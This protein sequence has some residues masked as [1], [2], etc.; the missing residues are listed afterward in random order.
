MRILYV[1][2]TA[3]DY[4]TATL[5]EGLLELGCE[6][7]ASEGSNY[8]D[9]LEDELIPAYA[10]QADLIVVGTN[11][12]VRV[13]LVR[14]MRNPRR[15]FVDGTDF[16][17][18][19]PPA[20]LRFKMIFKRELGRA[21]VDAA[22][23]YVFPL[24]FAA[25]RRYFTASPMQ[26]DILVSFLADLGS[27][28]LRFSIYQRLMN[29]R[30]PLV[31]TGVTGER[32]YRNPPLPQPI[33]TPMYREALNRSLISVSVPG[34]GYDCARYWE[35][36]AAKAM[37]LTFEPDIVIPE[38]FSDG[39]DCVSFRSFE[40]FEAKVAHYGNNV[41]LASAIAERGHARLLSHHTT[42]ARAAYFLEVV[43]RHIDRPGVCEP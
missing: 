37:L 31:Y 30:H 11:A 24:P 40:E 36:L 19:L 14:A 16:Q 18:L 15:V 22:A 38:G 20:D 28:P 3:Y 34:L 42:R 5:V 43:R 9:K 33:E 8:A 1:N 4:L 17:A 27:N 2:T 13:D 26:K 10:E 39:V 21:F 23:S 32:A 12:G 35:I 6:V 29:L 41:D 25:E 7:R